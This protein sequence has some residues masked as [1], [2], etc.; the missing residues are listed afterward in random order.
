M[1]KTHIAAAALTVITSALLATSAVAGNV[2]ETKPECSDASAILLA[3]VGNDV[4]AARIHAFIEA[5]RIWTDAAVVS[6]DLAYPAKGGPTTVYG[7]KCKSGKACNNLAHA[8]A[9]ANAD[10]S[11]TAFCG[12]TIMLRTETAR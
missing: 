4:Q 3:G 11:P 1:K 9:D 10:S 5:Q 6:W 12:G 7:V 8:F 2:T